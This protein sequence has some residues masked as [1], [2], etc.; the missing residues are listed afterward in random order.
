ML[1]LL[2]VQTLLYAA[3]YGDAQR[4]MRL[5]A[6]GGEFITHLWA[7]LYHLGIDRWEVERPAPAQEEESGRARV[8]QKLAAAA[9]GNG[10]RLRRARS[11]P[12]GL[13]STLC[14]SSSSS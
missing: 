8:D 10:T 2:W 6:E 3:P 5:L 11:V 7:L 9:G 1:A 13:G 4:H 12:A 14:C